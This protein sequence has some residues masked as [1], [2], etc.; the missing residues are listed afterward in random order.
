[1]C[2]LEIEA[3]LTL[4]PHTQKNVLNI[5]LS[6]RNS[7]EII[8]A[9]QSSQ[10]TLLQ[11]LSVLTVNYM[12]LIRLPVVRVRNMIKRLHTTAL[13]NSTQV[14]S[15]LSKGAMVISVNLYI[16]AVGEREMLCHKSFLTR[17]TTWSSS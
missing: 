1:M 17:I 12:L 15:Y 6:S 10:N 9:I 13:H 14:T 3:C 11:M 16:I 8:G 5:Q 4:N 2:V 7:F